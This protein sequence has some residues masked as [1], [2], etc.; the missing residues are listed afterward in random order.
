MAARWQPAGL[1][2]VARL[3]LGQDLRL[4]LFIE[5]PSH[6]LYLPP[7]SHG[8][9]AKALEPN[10]WTLEARPEGLIALY[11]PVLWNFT[12]EGEPSSIV[13]YTVFHASSGTLLCAEPFP[14]GPYVVELEGDTLEVPVILHLG[15]LLGVS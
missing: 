10:R 15:A 13:G 7:A 9:R 1:E 2:W 4:G 11:P 5:E 14:A 8:Y 12:D 3:L 6:L